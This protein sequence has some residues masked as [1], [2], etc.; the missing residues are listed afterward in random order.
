MSLLFLGSCSTAPTTAPASYADPVL[1]FR[2]D[3]HRESDRGDVVV[4][5]SPTTSP[6]PTVRPTP[7]VVLEVSPRPSPQP[8]R[9]RELPRGRIVTG[10]ASTYGP[11]FDGLLALPD[12]RGHRVTI[13]SPVTHR[14]VDRV[15]NDAGPVPSLHRVADLD[16]RT[17]EYLCNCKWRVLGVQPV[18]VTYHDN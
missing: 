16:V 1:S 11:G 13:C 2:P 6:Q 15:S 12:G 14:C 5:S 4:G 17:F 10:T 18:T 9:K 3:L 7:A 8:T